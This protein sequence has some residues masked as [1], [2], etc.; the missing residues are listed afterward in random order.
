MNVKVN[1]WLRFFRA[2][3]LPTVPGDVFAGAAVASCGT[4]A[5]LGFKGV[6]ATAAAAVLLYMFG[7]ADNDIVGAATD[8]DR[9][10][11]QGLISLTAARIA[12]ALCLTGVLVLALAT[13]L[14]SI[15]WPAAFALALAI[16]IYN[17][18]KI[19]VLMG[20]CRGLNLACGFL[21][22]YDHIPANTRIA[23]IAALIWTV[24]IAAVTKY[25]EGE[26]TDPARKRRVGL[27]IGALVWLQLAAALVPTA[28]FGEWLLLVA[29]LAMIALLFLFK[30]LMPKVSAS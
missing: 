20:L 17:R 29:Q 18:T 16:V 10:I 11:P 13:K 21:A 8:T 22:A 7:L 9:P 14:P 25:S 19:P 30:S 3:N 24:Y 23:I 6:A 1:G 4:P 2:V 5:I 15:W 12:R 26:E 27:L 28:I